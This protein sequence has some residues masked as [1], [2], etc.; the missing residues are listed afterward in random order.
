[1]AG[2]TSYA[3][4][5]AGPVQVDEAG[6]VDG[7]LDGVK[8]GDVIRIDYGGQ[9]A[10][11][12]P[13]SWDHVAVWWE[14]KSDPDGP[15]KGGADGKLDGYDLVA[16]MGHPHL[17]VEPLKEQAPAKIDVLRWNDKKLA[18]KKK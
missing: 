11:S 17:V 7:E 10:N 8:V 3:D 16:H 13:R 18:R 5:I 14:D 1:V 2:L 6:A 15:E 9:W 12:T 4:L